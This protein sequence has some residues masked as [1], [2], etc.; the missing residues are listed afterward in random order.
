MWI[1]IIFLP[2]NF[3]LNLLIIIDGDNNFCVVAWMLKI[4]YLIAITFILLY[5]IR[6]INLIKIALVLAIGIRYYFYEIES[7]YFFL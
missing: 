5:E 7:T 3:I 2:S 6:F 4:K 1:Q